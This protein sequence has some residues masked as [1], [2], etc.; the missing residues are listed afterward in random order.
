MWS[1]NIWKKVNENNKLNYER[2][3]KGELVADVPALLAEN[4]RLRE[5]L[6]EARDWIV[7][8]KP[9]AYVLIEI[10]AALE[11]KIE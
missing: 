9:N 3:K 2:R 11:K 5:A 6:E 10:D 4:K 8:E 7:D 1:R